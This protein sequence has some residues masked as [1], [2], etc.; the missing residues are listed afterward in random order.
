[1]GC[2]CLFFIL[3]LGV[4]TPMDDWKYQGDGTHTAARLVQPL[5]RVELG[6]ETK[7]GI[8]FSFEHSSQAR[9][10]DVGLNALWIKKRWQ[11]KR[12]Q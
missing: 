3:G 11:A 7:N 4:S 10:G 5:G 1:M 6:F 12:D 2:E 9:I 8:E